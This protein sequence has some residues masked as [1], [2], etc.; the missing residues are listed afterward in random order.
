MSDKQDPVPEKVRDNEYRGQVLRIA[1]PTPLRRL[2][3]YLPPLTG[4]PQPQPGMRVQVPFGNRKLV[5]MLIQVS[6]NSSLSRDKLKPAY[7]I[8]DHQPLFTPAV[9]EILLWAAA[10]YQHPI[11]EV[12]ATAIPARLRSANPLHQE[13]ELWSSSPVN[14]ASDRKSLDR[15]PK[16]KALLDYIELE[17][18]VSAAQCLQAGFSKQLLRELEKKQV[19]VRS[20]RPVP[21]DATFTALKHASDRTLK[22]TDEQQI[23]VDT[24]AAA[25]SGY[26]CFLLDGVT[27]S[28]KTEVYMHI[29]QQQL[30]AAKQCLV[31]VPEI[32]LTPQTVTRFEHRFNCR[33]AALHSGLNDTERFEAWRAARDGS[34]GIVIGTRSAI[35]TPLANP[36]LIIVDEEHDPS[37]KQQDGFRYSARDLAVMRGREEN[38]CVILGS[39]TPSLESLHNAKNHKFNYLQLQQRAGGA[40]PSTMEVV[41]ISTGSL[42]NGFSEQLLFKMQRHLDEKNQVLVFINRRGFAPILNCRNCGWISECENCVAQLTVHAN[43]PSIRCHHCGTVRQLP[44]FCPSCKSRDLG[45]IGLGTQK[46]ESFLNRHFPQTPVLRI[47]RDSTRSKRRLTEMLDQVHQGDPCIL[48]G[49]QMLAK[50][51]HFPNITL[52]AVVDA[53]A[54][55]FSADFRGQ[56]HMA[57]TIIQVAGRAGRAERAGEVVIQSR[58]S[59]HATLQGLSQGSYADFARLLFAEREQTTMPPFS[60]LCLIRA[61]AKEVNLPMSFL[62]RVAHTGKQVCEQQQLRVEQLGPVPAPMERRAGRFRVQLL[63]K[64]DSRA[65]LQNLLSVLT[66]KMEAMK[67]PRRLRWSVDIDPLELI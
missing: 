42:E 12:F 47:D 9:F 11:G 18:D 26:S 5:G 32:G 8:L 48:L 39:A 6:K 20:T 25:L 28:G 44:Q 7:A 27:G 61:E 41:D 37:F 31:L 1:V 56:E 65:D 57:Q 38:V 4:G 15:A 24:I 50:G 16:Q 54:G 55:L 66:A 35:F 45:T 60:H 29:M 33:V 58:H 52:V 64:S 67:P 40:S 17:G 59:T 19:V 43:P 2:F 46:I 14:R 21:A 30:A 49:T 23:A 3:D 22:L 62:K 36:G 63:L 10:Y 53:D 34:V 13:L 51:H